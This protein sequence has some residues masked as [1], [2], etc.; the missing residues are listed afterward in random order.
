MLFNYDKHIK[1]ANTWILFFIEMA[2][3]IS[4]KLNNWKYFIY[5][6]FTN[7]SYI[8]YFYFSNKIY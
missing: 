7:G 8:N 1:I 3:K 2:S 6:I 5:S 4:L